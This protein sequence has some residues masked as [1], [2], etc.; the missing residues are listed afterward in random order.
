MALVFCENEFCIYQKQGKCILESIQL[1]I[2]GNC[3][4]C[5]CV[6]IEENSLNNLKGQL[7]EKYEESV[8]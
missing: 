4:E 3:I 5:I 6:N 2:R 8:F 1:D 7:L